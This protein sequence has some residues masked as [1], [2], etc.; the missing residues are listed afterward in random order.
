MSSYSRDGWP[1]QPKT[2]TVWPFTE[3]IL[4]T[5]DFTVCI[6]WFCLPPCTVPG[7]TVPSRVYRNG[8]PWSCAVCSLL[9]RTQPS[10]ALQVLLWLSEYLAQWRQLAWRHL[11]SWLRLR[12]DKDRK[13][14]LPSPAGHIHCFSWLP[15]LRSAPCPQSPNTRCAVQFVRVT[16]LSTHIC[17]AVASDKL[18]LLSVP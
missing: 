12:E 3:K 9:S 17:L 11:K 2:F 5:L 7:S 1:S 15:V 8:L 6:V 4:M 18:F 10:L 16:H 14:T 13:G